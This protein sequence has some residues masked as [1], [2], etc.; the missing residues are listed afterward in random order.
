MNNFHRFQ[1]VLGNFLA[2][3]LLEVSLVV[4][5]LSDKNR[6]FAVA[7]PEVGSIVFGLSDENRICF[8]IFETKIGFSR[9]VS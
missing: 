1:R 2:V 8:W 5:G 4:F 9:G 3:A 6:I 7:L